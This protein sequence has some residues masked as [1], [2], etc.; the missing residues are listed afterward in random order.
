MVI[1]ALCS[2]GLERGNPRRFRS[3]TMHCAGPA[4][5]NCTS[6]VKPTTKT[7]YLLCAS[8]HACTYL[9][10]LLSVTVRQ[11]GVSAAGDLAL[12]DVHAG[13]VPHN[14]KSTLQPTRRVHTYLVQGF[15][16]I[17]V[18]MAGI[19]AEI[20]A[21]V[22]YCALDRVCSTALLDC[23]TSRGGSRKPDQWSSRRFPAS[24]HRLVGR[25]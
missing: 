23:P 12:V 2:S 24:K 4:T 19:A 7:S 1:H 22:C 13:S 9:P 6:S 17:A 18:S 14:S 25:S 3:I 11:G 15:C 20:E 8:Y 10:G 5:Y 21:K 16:L